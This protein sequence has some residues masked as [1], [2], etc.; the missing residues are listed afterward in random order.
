MIKNDVNKT[1]IT[2]SINISAEV[3]TTQISDG[4]TM[5]ATTPTCWLLSEVTHFVFKILSVKKNNIRTG[6]KE[7]SEMYNLS[8]IGQ[9]KLLFHF[10]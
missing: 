5:K 2:S 6:Q 7:M 8:L 3:K 9:L 10:I 4:F 1:L